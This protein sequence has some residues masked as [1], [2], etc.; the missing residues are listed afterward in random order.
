MCFKT[1]L[2]YFNYSVVPLPLALGSRVSDIFLNNFSMRSTF[3]YIIISDQGTLRVGV[4]SARA[5]LDKSPVQSS[6]TSRF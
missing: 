5:G 1:M 4:A 6:G 3:L 2:M